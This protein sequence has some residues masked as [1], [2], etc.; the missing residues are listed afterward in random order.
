MIVRK[1]GFNVFGRRRSNRAAAPAT[2]HPTMSDIAWAAGIYEGEGHCRSVMGNSVRLSVSQKDLWILE[3]LRS[4]FGGTVYLRK[5][6]GAS[7]C[8]QWYLSGTRARGFLFTIYSFLS[9]WRRK[10]AKEALCS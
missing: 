6:N 5:P 1:D 4:L 8:N 10:Q 2:L 3:R 9:P 7:V